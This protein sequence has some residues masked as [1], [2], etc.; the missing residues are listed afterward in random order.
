[1]SNNRKTPQ[2]T[3]MMTPQEGMMLVLKL[4]LLEKCPKKKASA[5]QPCLFLFM[6]VSSF[7]S[8]L[9][10]R[11]ATFHS[12]SQLRALTRDFSTGKDFW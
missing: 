8:Q 7:L 2:V 4:F 5:G 1:M 11:L 3:C 6:P 12:T 10:F 9:V